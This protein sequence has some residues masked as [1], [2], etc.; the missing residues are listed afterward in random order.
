[1]VH[2]GTRAHLELDGDQLFDLVNLVIYGCIGVETWNDDGGGIGG[3]T[4]SQWVGFDGCGHRS[5]RVQRGATPH[6]N[7]GGFGDSHRQV[8]KYQIQTVAN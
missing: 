6:D 5:T 2:H 7:G 8:V 3:R 1:M 4:P